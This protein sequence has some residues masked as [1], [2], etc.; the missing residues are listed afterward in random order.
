M[1]NIENIYAKR[2]ESVN[3]LQRYKTNTAKKTCWIFVVDINEEIR[4][5]TV[6]IST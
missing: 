2:F 6:C 4:Y 3:L 1:A 5:M